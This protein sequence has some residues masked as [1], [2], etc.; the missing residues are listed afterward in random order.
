[1]TIRFTQPELVVRDIEL[2][3]ALGDRLEISLRDVVRNGDV[4]DSVFA[5]P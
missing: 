3:D 2:E 5:V 1:M 4:P